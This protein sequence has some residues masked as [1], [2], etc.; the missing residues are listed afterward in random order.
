MHGN[1]HEWC[2]DPY[3]DKLPGGPD[4]EGWPGPERVN[5]GGSWRVEAKICRSA[6]RGSFPPDVKEYYL[7][8]RIAAVPSGKQQSP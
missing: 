4:P 1:V 3:S 2:W 6:F 8:F 5:K 7:G